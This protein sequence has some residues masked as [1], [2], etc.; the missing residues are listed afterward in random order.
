ME[1]QLLM[2][3]RT[4][5]HSIN[6][7]KTRFNSHTSSI[8]AL[9]KVQCKGKTSW[10]VLL[11]VHVGW[12][13]IFYEMEEELIVTWKRLEKAA[14]NVCCAMR[15]LFFFPFFFFLSVELK[16]EISS[17]FICWKVKTCPCSNA[18]F[19]TTGNTPESILKENYAGWDYAA[20]HNADWPDFFHCWLAMMQQRGAETNT[21]RKLFFV[22]NSLSMP[23]LVMHLYTLWCIVSCST[24]SKVLINVLVLVLHVT[25]R[26][27][28]YF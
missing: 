27:K 7:V 25:L 26:G 22:Q 8:I 15:K 9:V 13:C 4:D 17:K 21:C 20:V 23:D 2:C 19:S 24:F 16:M 28:V 1:P 3:W 12:R 18:Y 14:A 5:L 11:A 10:I 6:A